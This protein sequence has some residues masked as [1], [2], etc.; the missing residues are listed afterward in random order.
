MGCA[1]IGAR[2]E[3]SDGRIG[4]ARIQIY[5]HEKPRS[6]NK[7]YIAAVVADWPKRGAKH[8]GERGRTGCQHHRA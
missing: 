7:K 1:G 5:G 3:R 8:D 2:C 6:L 4:V